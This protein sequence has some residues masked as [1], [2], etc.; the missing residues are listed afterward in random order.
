MLTNAKRHL[1]YYK[2]RVLFYGE[3]LKVK[4]NLSEDTVPIYHIHIRKTAGTTINFAFL[5]NANVAD[6]EALYERMAAKQTRRVIENG[7]VFLGWDRMAINDGKYHYAFSHFPLH[8]L[9]LPENTYTFTCLR[10]PVKRVLSHYNMLRHYQRTNND[11]TFMK[12]EGKWLGNS[13]TDFLE[14]VPKKHLLNQLYMFSSTFSVEE[15]LTKLHSLNRVIFTESL[16]EGLQKLEEDTGW[17][18]PISNQK[19][20]GYK[21]EISNEDLQKLRNVMQPEYELL[22]RF[23]KETQ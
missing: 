19:K 3:D 20:Y 15:A 11:R 7:N 9:Q 4:E 23:K 16:S 6:V 13:F 8:E 14:K 5:S 18:L 12:V 22:E 17:T 1:W 21:E 10:D 2:N